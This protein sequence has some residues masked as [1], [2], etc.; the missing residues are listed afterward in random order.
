MAT[1]RPSRPKRIAVANRFR[2]VLPRRVEREVQNL[3]EA[4]NDTAVPGIRIV[5]VSFF[6]K[7]AAANTTL[8]VGNQ[9]FGMCDLMNPQPATGPAGTLGIVEH[10]VLRL[11]AAIYEMVSGAAERLVETFHLLLRC[12][13]KDF[14]AHKPISGQQR[15][16]YAGFDGLFVLPRNNEPINDGIHVTHLVLIDG[17]L[18]RDIDL[19]AIDDHQAAALFAYFGQNKIEFLAVDLEHRRAHFDFRAFRQRQNDFKDTAG[20]EAGHALASTRAVRCGH[21]REEQVEVAGDVGHG[22]DGRSRIAADGLLFD[23]DD[24]REAEDEVHVRLCD[25]SDKALGVARQRFEIA[26]LA[27][28]IDGVERQAGFPGTGE[29][30]YD[31]QPVSW[32]F[33]RDISSDCERARPAPRWCFA[34]LVSILSAAP[35]QSLG[36]SSSI[37]DV[38]RWKKASSSTLMLLFLVS[39]TGSEAFPIRPRSERYSQTPV[40]PLM[41]KLR[42]K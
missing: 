34:A 30:R 8:R 22:A 20:T 26:A 21:R 35:Y 42:R 4:V 38:L 7:A 40:T 2:Q 5:F 3:R 32:E 12:A 24:G 16:G 27:F 15:C 25:L 41:P 31:D 18:I 29:T 39:R 9:Q 19:L 36:A 10:E 14:H 13:L 33:D 1:F 28:R 6:E 11:D 23:R 37:T 17:N